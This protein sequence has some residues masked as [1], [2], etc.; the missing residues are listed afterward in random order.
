MGDDL[1]P[2]EVSSLLGAPPSMA[3]ARG[4]DI[5]GKHDPVRVAKSGQ[6]SYYAPDTEPA[7]VD[8]QVAQ[9]LGQLTPDIEV[10]QQLADR[11]D[12][13]LFSGWFMDG[14]NEGL[15]ISP[16]TLMSLAKRRIV[17]SLDIYGA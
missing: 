4:D 13:D 1:I 9:L 17:L 10:W 16:D 7:D 5:T 8:A 2:D 14:A 15:A 11:F 12:L 6:W 3:Y